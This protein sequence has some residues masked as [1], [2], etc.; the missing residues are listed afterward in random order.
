MLLE[1]GADVNARD[2]YGLTPQSVAPYPL[3]LQ[4]YLRKISDA[5]HD[6]L[7]SKSLIVVGSEL[8]RVGSNDA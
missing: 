7:S 4:G 6:N 5:G 2:N 8:M 3:E 1:Y